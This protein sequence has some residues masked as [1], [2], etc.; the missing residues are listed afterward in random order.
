V[1]R[2]AEADDATEVLR[3]S[4]FAAGF[5]LRPDVDFARRREPFR[6]ANFAAFAFKRRD[7]RAAGDRFAAFLIIL[8]LCFAFVAMSRAEL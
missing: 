7:L 4:T 6:D 5:D 1:D 8:D 3:A 2:D